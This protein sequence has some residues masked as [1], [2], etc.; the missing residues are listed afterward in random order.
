MDK[1]EFINKVSNGNWDVTAK[2]DAVIVSAVAE[3]I[4]L[5]SPGIISIGK[6]MTVDISEA[7][8]TKTDD[9]YMLEAGGLCFTFAESIF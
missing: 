8:I 7:E 2:N 5:T 1:I 3:A 6:V 9:G 4:T